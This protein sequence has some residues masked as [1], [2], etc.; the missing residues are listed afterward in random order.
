MGASGVTRTFFRGGGGGG[1]GQDFCVGWAGS[2][3]SVPIILFRDGINQILVG[4]NNSLVAVLVQFSGILLI[5][6]VG[7]KIENGFLI[8]FS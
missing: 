5:S 8:T 7:S 1:L 2:T 6:V 4:I 3:N